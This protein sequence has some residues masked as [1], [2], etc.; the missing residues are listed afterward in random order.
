MTFTPQDAERLERLVQSHSIRYLTDE[1][2]QKVV[3]VWPFIERLLAAWRE[4]EASVA[5][6]AAALN[7]DDY[8]NEGTSAIR[9]AVKARDAAIGDWALRAAKAQEDADALR[10]RLAALRAARGSET[11]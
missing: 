1:S 7:A 11:R 9:K 10:A 4:A 3:E 5:E 8:S 6:F 2:P